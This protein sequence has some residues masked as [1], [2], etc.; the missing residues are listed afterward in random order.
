MSLYSIFWPRDLEVLSSGT[1]IEPTP[2]AAG[3]WSPDSWT[4]KEFPL[5][6]LESNFILTVMPHP[7]WVLSSLKHLESAYQPLLSWDLRDGKGWEE[8]LP[9]L[10]LHPLKGPGKHPLAQPV[11]P[12][13]RGSVAFR[14]FSLPS[15]GLFAHIQGLPSVSTRI[16][17]PPLHLTQRWSSP[18]AP[19]PAQP[20]WVSPEKVCASV[21]RLKGPQLPIC[22]CLLGCRNS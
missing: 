7:T 15:P 17:F 18:A 19:F 20:A 5:Y 16:I 6:V 9:S 8:V 3:V 1:G 13:S 4:A 12:S 2:S 11:G 14:P 10:V 21:Q 22:F